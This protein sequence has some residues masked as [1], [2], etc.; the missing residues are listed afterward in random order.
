VIQLLLEQNGLS[1]E[2]TIDALLQMTSSPSPPAKVRI[3]FFFGLDISRH[4][5]SPHE[6][7]MI[8]FKLSSEGALPATPLPSESPA[9]G[10]SQQQIHDDELLAKALQRELRISD[11]VRR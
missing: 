2:R 4:D 11:G 8:L 6:G 10:S 7:L 9:L 3:L 5:I 1:E